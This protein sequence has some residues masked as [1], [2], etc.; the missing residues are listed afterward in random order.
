MNEQLAAIRARR[1][2]ITP[3]A[4]QLV[5]MGR[6]FAVFAPHPV[7]SGNTCIAVVDGGL[8]ADSKRDGEFIAAAPADIDT[9][10][11]MVDALTGEAESH[12][13][14]AEWLNAKWVQENNAVAARTAERDALALELSHLRPEW[15]TVCAER[16]ALRAQA[17]R[18][19]ADQWRRGNAG[20]EPQ[21]F[22]EWQRKV[23]P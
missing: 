1:A 11:A 9:L 14:D 20:Q 10:L 5:E 4:W 13:K 12:R 19:G 8:T 16:D 23:Q 21:E 2:A 22:S 17:D 3:G 7:E 6:D 15:R 18:Y